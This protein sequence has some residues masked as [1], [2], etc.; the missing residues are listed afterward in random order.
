MFFYLSTFASFEQK[1]YAGPSLVFYVP[2]CG[3]EGSASGII[4]DVLLIFECGLFAILGFTVLA[5]N[6]VY[7]L[8]G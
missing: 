5:N 7:V 6:G 2:Y 1:W 4:R 8:D 3:T